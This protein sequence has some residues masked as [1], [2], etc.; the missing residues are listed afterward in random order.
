MENRFIIKNFEGETCIADEK[1][2]L[3]IFE[4]IL[5][6]RQGENAYYKVD[7][8]IEEMVNLID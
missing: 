8:E 5:K 4:E 1:S 6:S 7:I 2:A 3:I